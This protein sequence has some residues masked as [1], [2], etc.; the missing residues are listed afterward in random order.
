M[1]GNVSF[2][3]KGITGSLSFGEIVSLVAIVIGSI[4]A[5]I[6]VFGFF[7]DIANVKSFSFRHGFT[8]YQDGETKKKRFYH[9][10]APVAKRR[11]GK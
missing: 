7:C 5:I 1:N 6:M 8:F 3:V 9:K 2:A 11:T 4:L 10:K